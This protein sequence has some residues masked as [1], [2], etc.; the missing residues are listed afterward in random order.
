MKV[1]NKELRLIHIKVIFPVKF[2]G[3]ICNGHKK[4]GY[5]YVSPLSNFWSFGIQL[6]LFND[7]RA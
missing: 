1:D 4:R 5:N 3:I 6:E 7:V 2:K